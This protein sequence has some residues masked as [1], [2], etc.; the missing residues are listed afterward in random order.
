MAAADVN[1]ELIKGL[2]GLRM[3]AT[4]LPEYN[5]TELISDWLSYFDLYSQDTRWTTDDQKLLYI[6]SHFSHDVK[7]WFSL[8]PDATKMDYNALR[9]AL[10]DKH[11]PSTPEVLRAKR[12]T[13]AAQQK[14]DQKF[15]D[16][17]QYIQIKAREIGCPDHGLVEIRGTLGEQV[18]SS[19]TLI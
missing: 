8:L 1:Q 12:T 13:Y 19:Q 16:F 7:Q 10:V 2:Q 3:L 9:Q 15:K 18:P 14:P 4:M 11:S 17:V 6:I 5:G